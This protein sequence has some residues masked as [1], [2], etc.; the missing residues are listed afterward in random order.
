MAIALPAILVFVNLLG[1]PTK[2]RYPGE[3]NFIEGMALAEMVHLRQGVRIYATPSAEGYDGANY[4]P[5]YYI[6]GAQLID[7]ERPVYLPLRVLSLAGTLTIALLLGLM[8]YRLSGRFTAATMAALLFLSYGFV[9]RHASSAR[10]DSVA[11]TLLFAG[12]TVAHRWRASRAILWA[13]PLMVAGFYYKQQFVAAPLAVFIYL[14]TERRFRLAAEFAGLM[15]AALLALL[16]LWQFVIFRNQAFLNHFVLQNIHPYRSEEILLGLGFFGLILFVPLLVSLEYL[17]KHRDRLLLTYLICAFG[18]T[19]VTVARAGADTNFFLECVMI[20]CVL[21]SAYYAENLVEPGRAP[22]LLTLLGVTLFVGLWGRMPTPSPRDF[23]DDANVQ[24]YLTRQFPRGTRTLSYFS[25]D[26]IRAGLSLPFTNLNHYNQLI[27]KGLVSGE[28]VPGLIA[29][30]RF[31]LILL[32]F[33]LEKEQSDYYVNF[34]LTPAM[35]EAIGKR[36][37][38]ADTLEMPSP[39]KMLEHAKYYVWVPKSDSP[40]APPP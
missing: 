12:F 38:L 34:Y 32:D 31:G 2:L 4:G 36:Y 18:L 14:L 24:A 9:F 40:N 1:L 37:R 28:D 16:A 25:G 6:V 20:C 27:R 23:R 17:R 33:D 39:E 3:L 10:S 13:V 19:L 35:R 30:Q 5:L 11:L 26:V 29:Q 22:E 21:F 7:T 8:A 15:T